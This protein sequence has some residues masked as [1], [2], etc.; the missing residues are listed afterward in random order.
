MPFL[1]SR[2]AFSRRC[3]RA[4]KSRFTPAGFPMPE[5]VLQSRRNV[6][7]LCDSQ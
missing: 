5:R 1:S 2:A 7:I 3:S 6:T 4:S